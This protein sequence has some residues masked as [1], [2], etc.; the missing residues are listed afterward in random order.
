MT[1][2]T[3]ALLIRAA[4][5]STFVCWWIASIIFVIYLMTGVM[6]GG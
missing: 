1:E 5:M 3:T 2:Q 6:L 4:L